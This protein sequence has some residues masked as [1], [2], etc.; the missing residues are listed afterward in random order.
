MM[1]F[2]HLCWQQ[3]EWPAPGWNPPTINCAV[4]TIV[5]CMLGMPNWLIWSSFICAL[6]LQAVLVPPQ[7]WRVMTRGGDDMVAPGI[8]VA[9][10]QA[11]CSLTAMT[12]G[13]MRRYN[14][15]RVPT[16]LG[17]DAVTHVLVF[18]SVFVV[19]LTVVALW[20]RRHMIVT[21][22]FKPSWA[23]ITFPSCSSALAI[24]QYSGALGTGK[25]KG[26]VCSGEVSVYGDCGQEGLELNDEAGLAAAPALTN[27]DETQEWWLVLL[28]V[29]ALAF[30]TTV[31][32]IVFVVTLAFFRFQFMN[33]QPLVRMKK[34]KKSQAIQQLKF[35][36]KPGSAGI[37]AADHSSRTNK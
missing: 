2:L 12:W 30:A 27:V 28:R 3:G 15:A 10:M 33:E 37:N 21:E 8:A 1:W 35:H 14:K 29:Y 6:A 11:P 17:V 34:V 24:L 32:C 13:I 22:G 20:R 19:W 7:V 4:T 31:S 16:W 26:E 18:F 5:S 36:D 9:L 25:G 23:A